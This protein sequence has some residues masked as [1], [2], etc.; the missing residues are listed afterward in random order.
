MQMPRRGY[1]YT[2]ISDASITLSQSRG[3]K[4]LP[5]GLQSGRRE[6]RCP[7]RSRTEFQLR[8][9]LLVRIWLLVR[10]ILRLQLLLGM[11]RVQ[12]GVQGVEDTA[13]LS[14]GRRVRP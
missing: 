7:M 9:A 12:K 2:T 13:Q 14:F 1:R 11:M 6:A 8:E 5:K 10:Q 3:I 4:M